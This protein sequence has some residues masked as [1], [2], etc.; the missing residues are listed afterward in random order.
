MTTKQRLVFEMAKSIA[1]TVTHYWLSQID[2]TLQ[3][4]EIPRFIAEDTVDQAERI[5]EKILQNND[6]L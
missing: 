2:T 3:Q 4:R 6:E 5:V 1:P